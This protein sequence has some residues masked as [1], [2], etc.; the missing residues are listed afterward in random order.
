M[1][2]KKHIINKSILRAYDIRGEVG[3]TLQYEDGYYI[4]KAF[5]TKLINKTGVKNPKIALCYDGRI[6]SPEMKNQVLEGLQAAGCDITYIG[7][8]PSPMMYYTVRSMN[9]D[10]GIMVTA[11]HNPSKD[12]G[13]KMMYKK[14][15]LFGDEIKEIGEISANGKF[16]DNFAEAKFQKIDISE[17]YIEKLLTA[18]EG[19][20]K[21]N[22]NLKNLTI[23]WDTGNAAASKI[24]ES[25]V[26]KLPNK[27]I[28]I[29]S[30]ID[31]TFPNHHP[32]PT[33]AENLQQLIDEVKKN[34]ADLGIAFD[35]DGDRIGTVDGQGRIIWGD[36]LMTLYA[37]DVL[38]NLPNSEIIAD[39]KASQSFFDRVTELGGKPLMWKTGHSYIKNKLAE[40]GAPLA[41]E[42][43]GHIFFADRY[44]GYD[45]A[46]YAALRLINYFVQTNIKPYQA[47]DKLPK[48]YASKE[49]RVPV[50]EAEKENIVNEIKAKVLA[51]KAKIIEVD[52]IRVIERGGWWLVRS[53]NTQSVLTIRAESTSDEGLKLLIDKISGFLKTYNASLDNDIGH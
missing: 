23:V 51:S 6:S 46:I 4:A 12:N 11:S 20:Y 41:G 45:D 33:I 27:N 25:L 10:G 22:K 28:I 2:E 42:M 7:L 5:A 19:D 26:K 37:E 43:S 18:F 35:G 24:T 36:Q 40:T 39:V 53:S 21:N 17:K 8:G 14:A 9:L 52:G 31:G 3:K 15:P 50:P 16:I 1:I 34:N 29:N 38:R 32:D 48:T 13:F 30:E 49:Y 47:V 44:Y